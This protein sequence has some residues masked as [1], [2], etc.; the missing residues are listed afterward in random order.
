MGTEWPCSCSFPADEKF[1]EHTVSYAHHSREFVQCHVSNCKVIQ[2]RYLGVEPLLQWN[3]AQ[4]T[5]KG[6]SVHHTNMLCT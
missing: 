5:I 3:L 2:T 6:I 1:H 4:I